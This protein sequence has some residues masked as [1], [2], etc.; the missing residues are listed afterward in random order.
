MPLLEILRD[1]FRDWQILI[2][3]HD[4]IWFEMARLYL[5]DDWKTVELY[6]YF[7]NA[8]GA[9]RPVVRGSAAFLDKA[10]AYSHLPV[11]ELPHVAQTA[12]QFLS[13]R[14]RDQLL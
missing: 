12:S 6:H 7:D 14:N 3:T 2:F 5:G 11:L 10:R 9:D 1:E 4:R 13:K 8:L